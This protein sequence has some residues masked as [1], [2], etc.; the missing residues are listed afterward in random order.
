M[1][2]YRLS[3]F[4]LNNWQ[5]LFRRPNEKQS[6]D[7]NKSKSK[8]IAHISRFQFQRHNSKSNWEEVIL[9]IDEA[10]GPHFEWDQYSVILRDYHVWFAHD[11]WVPKNKNLRFLQY[12]SKRQ[13]EQ[14][15]ERILQLG[16]T[17]QEYW[18]ACIFRRA[19]W[20]SQSW[21]YMGFQQLEV[22]SWVKDHWSRS[23]KTKGRHR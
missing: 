3:N 23:R 15:W 8:V 7:R 6:H 13:K 20:I 4:Q 12:Q 18:F 21:W 2:G 19:K 1:A 16:N 14:K 10:V 17:I 9:I 5:T 22:E 11:T